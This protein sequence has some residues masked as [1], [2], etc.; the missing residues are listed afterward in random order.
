MPEIAAGTT[1]AVL[2]GWPVAEN[3]SRSP[4]TTSSPTVETDKAVV[5]VEAETDGVLLRL[6][7]QPGAEVE[8]GAP[9]ALVGSPG[10]TVDD[11]DAALAALGVTAGAP[12]TAP[13][14]DP[15][16]LEV[17][18]ASTTPEPS[19][20]E[21]VPAPVVAPS[22]GHGTGRVFASP[23]ARRLAARGRPVGHG[24]PRHR[25]R[26]PDRPP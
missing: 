23:L 12:A 3:T 16:A 14:A 4:P 2:S 6:L 7:V 18:E 10:E 1:S 13:S 26:R 15:G 21:Q 20:V 24:H 17:P 8:V 5:D 11:V 19:P 22:N 9:I 25:A